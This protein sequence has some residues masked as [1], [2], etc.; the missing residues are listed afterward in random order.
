MTGLLTA[1]HAGVLTRQEAMEA[2]P[3][4]HAPGFRLRPEVVVWF[5]RESERS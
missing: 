5:E 3:Q 2:V 4:L 1:L